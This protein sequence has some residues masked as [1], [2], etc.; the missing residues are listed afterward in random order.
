MSCCQNKEK[1]Y[2]ND[3]TEIRDCI[4]GTEDTPRKKRGAGRTLRKIAPK[5][6]D[7]EYTKNI[8]ETNF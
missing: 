6:I 5:G 4:R 2:N 7:T 8:F 1:E 3:D